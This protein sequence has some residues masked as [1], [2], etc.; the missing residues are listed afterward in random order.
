MR[1]RRAVFTRRTIPFIIG[2]ILLVAVAFLFLT[3][4]LDWTYVSDLYKDEPT[5][6]VAPDAEPVETVEL[7]IGVMLPE[8]QYNEL[9]VLSRRVEERYPYIQVKINN[10]YNEQLT[11]EEWQKLAQLG[12]LGDIQL[13]NNEWVVP[14]AIQ[15]LFQPVD[16]LMNNDVLSDQLHSVV[17]AL[18]W[19]GYMWAVPYE[20]N[21]YLL[22]MH[23][24]AFDG[25]ESNDLMMVKS[26]P[27][28]LDDSLAL[29]DVVTP[30]SPASDQ[31][32][33]DETSAM[34]W[35]FKHWLEQYQQLDS[36]EGPLMS[37]DPEQLSGLLVWLSMWNTETEEPMQLG[38]VNDAQ[39]EVLQYLHNH[40]ELV[41]TSTVLDESVLPFLYMTTV[42]QYYEQRELIEAHYMSSKAYAP[43]PW[44]NGKSF[45]MS[46][47]AKD[48]EA[49]MLWLETLN[50]YQPKGTVIQRKI[51]GSYSS[52]SMQHKLI[53]SL[54]EKLQTNQLFQYD[55]EWVQRYEQLEQGWRSAASLQE[56]L[57]TLLN[58][59][60]NNKTNE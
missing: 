49:A 60:D 59:Y 20:T 8:D 5:V 36:F 3:R 55:L 57:T 56:K 38:R 52:D 41:Q 25:D 30:T 15:G 47:S 44:L 2:S 22:F 10:F 24:Q 13:V 9:I 48:A 12:G 29:K 58:E 42:K 27:I 50:R 11:F 6:V 26:P 46:A 54:Q 23:K 45:M 1:R 18:K 17:D 4:A 39:Y 21:P 19:N 37:L 40:G 51:Y 32:V 31:A 33:E 16:R 7:E 34:D 53:E 14:L 43:L 35:G 28:A